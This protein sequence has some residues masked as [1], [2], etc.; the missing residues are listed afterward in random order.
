MENSEHKI[1]SF[2]TYGLVLAALIVFTLFSVYVTQLDLGN[3]SIVAA[4]AIAGLK[5]IL[6]FAIF[7]HLFY[8]KKMYAL[9]VLVVLLVMTMVLIITFLDYGYLKN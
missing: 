1:V 5:S 4:L 7:M 9:M 2:K 3:F 8:D 6:V